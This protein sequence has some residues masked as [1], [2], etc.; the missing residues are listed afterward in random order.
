MFLRENISLYLRSLISTA[1]AMGIFVCRFRT[2]SYLI[3]NQCELWPF[4]A[5]MCFSD[6]FWLS[7]PATSV[8]TC[9]VVECYAFCSMFDNFVEW[10]SLSKA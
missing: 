2:I 10:Y 1:S 8:G 7:S 3:D 4:S 6:N 5:E 9:C